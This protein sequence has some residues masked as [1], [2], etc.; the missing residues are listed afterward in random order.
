MTTTANN[1][2]SIHSVFNGPNTLHHEFTL[3]SSDVKIINNNNDNN[4]AA[5]AASRATD[6]P[7]L[8]QLCQLL[9]Q[10]KDENNR[11]LTQLLAEK[12]K[13]GMFMTLR[14]H[15]ALSR[16]SSSACTHAAFVCVKEEE[17]G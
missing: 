9:Q 15:H 5:A 2:I 10:T 11:Y 3:T 6:N 4:T 12:S 1:N 8:K 13:E 17:D 7:S 14:L 16:C